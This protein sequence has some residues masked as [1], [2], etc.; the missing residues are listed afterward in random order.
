MFFKKGIKLAV[1][2]SNFQVK[3]KNMTAKSIKHLYWIDRW[4]GGFICF[5]LTL[6]YKVLSFLKK[7][8]K[9]K[10]I[11]N[12][13]II[14]LSEMGSIIL[15]YP[16]LL[17]LYQ[18]YKGAKLYLLTFDQQ[19]SLVNLM[20]LKNMKIHFLK[21]SIKS[22][23]RF[24]IDLFRL[25]FHFWKAP[26]DIV[27]DF[28][29]FSRFS[30][31]ISGLS[32]APFRVGFSRYT[33]EGLYRGNFYSHA[34][35]YN[36]YQHISINFVA[37]IKSLEFPHRQKPLIQRPLENDL[38]PPVYD[39]SESQTINMRKKIIK[40]C[41]LA[42]TSKIWVLFNVGTGEPLPIRTWPME[43]FKTLSEMILS[44]YNAFI[45]LLGQ[46]DAKENANYIYNRI[47]K[48]RC[49]NAAGHLE[50][51]EL[52]ALFGCSDILITPDSGMAHL[53]SMT[54]I[55]SLVLF[56]PETPIRYSPLGKNHI[57]IF[58]NFSCSPCFSPHNHCQTNCIDAKCLKSI[59]PKHVFN[60]FNKV[61][62]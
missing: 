14:Q 58:K 46:S 29:R 25:F 11:K 18:K 36:N 26:F 21:I 19:D 39:L 9:E 57:N 13:L 47:R 22:N 5:V 16:A 56:G 53:A 17:D 33:D 15:S 51:Y 54:S 62:S 27:I 23:I 42:E 37:M 8:S 48:D 41:N 40:H 32:F 3:N 45:I 30:A 7:P 35:W 61:L 4:I 49:W 20:P 2:Y 24:I 60:E 1:K 6:I 28:E 59:T 31:L 34:V 12:I 55:K 43:H 38:K 10:L 44:Q 50:L 52:M